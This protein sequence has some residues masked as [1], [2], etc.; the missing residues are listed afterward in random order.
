M[1]N[2]NEN[3]VLRMLKPM[4]NVR[5]N[6]NDK[7]IEVVKNTAGNKTL[8]RIDYLVNY[9]GYTALYVNDLPT[10]KKEN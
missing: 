6:S 7:T 10:Y 9:C 1:A 5:V 8:G 3:A 2:Y 4:G